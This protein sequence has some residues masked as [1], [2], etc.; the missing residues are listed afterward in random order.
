MKCPKCS[1]LGFDTGDRCRNC[2]YD[3][4]LV[5]HP[6]S[7][8]ADVAA[9]QT[10]STVSAPAT[11]WDTHEPITDALDRLADTSMRDQPSPVMP[12][13][14]MNAAALRTS[15]PLLSPAPALE[16]ETLPLFSH[17][18]T[19][20]VPLVT[21]PAAPR[22]PLSVR[23]A[24]DSPRLRSAVT[25]RRQE[26][27]DEDPELDLTPAAVALRQP[28]NEPRASAVLPASDGC[29]W[30]AR[31]AAALLDLGILMAIDL[32]VF[33]FTLRMAALGFEEW[34]VL[35][36]APLVAFLLLIKV[37]YYWAFTAIGGQ[38]IG[39][40]AV[41]IR[42]VS[43]QGFTV[44]PACA[45]RRTLAAVTAIVTC[46]ATFLPALFAGDGRA[47]HDRLAHTRVVALRG[48]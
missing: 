5:S 35:P 47:M 22:A 1:Y 2:G 20:D 3:F 21:L 45:F 6:S 25:R 14:L 46:G 31:A 18:T 43:D 29:A 37:G 42:V 36:A 19:D 32:V 13:V 17:G 9:D 8:P 30:S 7:D 24:P 16:E 4:S 33:Y 44:A 23:R 41:H 12:D 10:L 26:W 38:T 28:L 34:R 11:G 48:A 15:A 39:K 40:M 27:D